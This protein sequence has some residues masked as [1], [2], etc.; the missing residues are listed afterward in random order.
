MTISIV[1]LIVSIAALF[2][3]FASVRIAGNSLRQ[4]NLAADR[5]RQD[6]RQS[7]WFDLYLEA[8]KAYDFFDYFQSKYRGKDNST[9]MGLMQDFAAEWNH[10]MALMR[11]THAMAAVFPKNPVINGLFSSTAVF[12]SPS[13]ALLP[14]RLLKM[15]NAVQNLREKAFLAHDVLDESSV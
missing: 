2:A 1:S 3:A 10:L 9:T 11:R 15:L 5:E 12:E 13:E 4:A 14:E 7:K 6:W 8:N